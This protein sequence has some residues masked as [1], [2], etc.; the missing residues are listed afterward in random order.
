MKTN[1]TLIAIELH[2]NEF[3]PSMKIITKV[4]CEITISMVEEPF[5]IS[6]FYEIPLLLQTP[7]LVK[8]LSLIAPEVYFIRAT[9]LARTFVADSLPPASPSEPVLISEQR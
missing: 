2:L 8:N 7:W 6:F 1:K 4:T 5:R 3:V 9:A